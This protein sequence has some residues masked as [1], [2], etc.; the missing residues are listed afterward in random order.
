MS[1]D[2]DLEDFLDAF[3]IGQAP[4]VPPPPEDVD[5]GLP[6]ECLKPV[7]A[8][9]VEPK[10]PTSPIPRHTEPVWVVNQDEVRA[11]TVKLARRLLEEGPYSLLDLAVSQ[12]NGGGI[13]AIYCQGGHPA[14]KDLVSMGSTCQIYLGKADPTTENGL[15]NRLKNHRESI[16]QVGLG[17]ENFTFRFVPLPLELVAFA[18]INL[19]LLYKPL[20]NEYLTGFGAKVQGSQRE[21][22]V[23]RWDIFH[24]GRKGTRGLKPS[25]PSDSLLAIQDGLSEAIEQCRA[26]YEAAMRLIGV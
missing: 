2:E 21:S 1:D 20:W 12:F 3:K 23:S 15:W 13:Y 16:D 4:S 7:L 24:P 8:P 6:V 11:S 19:L 5:A 9:I 25:D 26:R 10:V 17:P 18:E 14:Y 22:K